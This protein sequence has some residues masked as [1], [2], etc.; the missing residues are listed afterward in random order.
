MHTTVKIPNNAHYDCN[1]LIFNSWCDHLSFAGTNDFIFPWYW[2]GTLAWEFRG[3]SQ[4]K[5]KWLMHQILSGCLSKLSVALVYST[6][7]RSS[8]WCCDKQWG[9]TK[10]STGILAPPA[11]WNNRQSTHRQHSG[12]TS[13]LFDLVW[14]YSIGPTVLTQIKYN[15]WVILPLA[16]MI[17]FLAENLRRVIINCNQ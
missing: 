9:T 5:K 3:I 16:F 15:S 1:L 2:H 6:I 17:V 13:R 12:P 8:M 10:S 4:S 14:H 7:V 11:N